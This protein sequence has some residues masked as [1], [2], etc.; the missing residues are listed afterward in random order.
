VQR[1]NAVPEPAHAARPEAPS[2]SATSRI[3]HRVTYA[4]TDQMGVVYHTNYLV[5]CE[6]ARTEHLRARGLTYRDLEA[7][8][9]F[10]A[11]VDLHIRFHAAARYDD[12]VRIQCWVREIGSRRVTFGYRVRRADTGELLATADTSLIALN[13]QHAV[14]RV[15]EHVRD[16]LQ[17]I[18]D[19]VRS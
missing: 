12:V 8:G 18:P 3:D 19:P 1:L 5:W 14:S 11:V 6:M 15:P 10:L 9:V 2:E 4:E 16:L 7:Q 17:A 13:R